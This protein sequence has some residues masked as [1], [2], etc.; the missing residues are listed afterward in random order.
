VPNGAKNGAKEVA[1]EVP[2][3][4]VEVSRIS[5][6]EAVCFYFS[7]GL[8]HVET[9]KQIVWLVCFRFCSYVFRYILDINLYKIDF[10]FG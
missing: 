3:K 8:K 7:E 1:M 10:R 6:L 5:E 4:E 2:A 9:T